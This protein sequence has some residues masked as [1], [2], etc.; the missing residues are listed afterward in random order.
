M[1]NK[2][3][4]LKIYK[5]RLTTRQL[6]WLGTPLGPL[7]RL[8]GNTLASV[9]RHSI[10]SVYSI[11]LSLHYNCCL[12]GHSGRWFPIAIR[13][14][15]LKITRKCILVAYISLL[16]KISSHARNW[17]QRNRISQANLNVPETYLRFP[18]STLYMVSSDV[19]IQTWNEEIKGVSYH[20][21]VYK[22]SWSWGISI[23]KND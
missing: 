4:K 9:P 10:W 14:E 8:L 16:I 20:L 23:V 17:H 5:K 19:N 18:D 1:Q 6:T 15:W 21:R 7:L 12:T 22:W 13:F 11:T 3:W 2:C